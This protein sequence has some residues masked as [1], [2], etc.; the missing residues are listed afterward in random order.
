M[1]QLRPVLITWEKTD[2]YTHAALTYTYM[3]LS[4]IFC[5]GNWVFEKF[6]FVV[7]ISNSKCRLCL[8]NLIG[9][10]GTIRGFTIS[11]LSGD[12]LLC[13]S[14]NGSGYLL[15]TFKWL[16]D[17]SFCKWLFPSASL[18]LSSPSSRREIQGNNQLC[19]LSLWCW[20]SLNF[21]TAV[22]ES[23]HSPV[24]QRI[25]PVWYTKM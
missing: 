22:S 1:W 4:I 3:L 13:K 10:I 17:E 5:W 11:C 12:Y 21:H 16:C 20:L 6:H 23:D 19:F 7:D 18:G 8:K 2:C 24:S 14:L 15:E 9:F 25:Y